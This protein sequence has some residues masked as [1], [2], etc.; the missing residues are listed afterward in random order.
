[1]TIKKLKN[2]RSKLYY[3]LKRHILSPEFEWNYLEDSVTPND[4][5]MVL[6]KEEVNKYIDKEF[7]IQNPHIYT[8][9]FF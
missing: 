6:W 4:K 3:D 1:M 8:H 7:I 5:D 9:H 2:P